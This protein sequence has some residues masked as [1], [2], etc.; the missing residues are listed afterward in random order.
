VGDGKNYGIGIFT[1]GDLRQSN[2]EI[3][4]TKLKS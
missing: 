2:V 4:K 1:K 3:T